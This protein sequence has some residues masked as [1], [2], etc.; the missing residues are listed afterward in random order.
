MLDTG[1]RVTAVDGAGVAVVDI[2]RNVGD[3]PGLGVAA[4]SRARIVVV[5]VDRRVLHTAHGVAAVHGTRVVVVDLRRSARL[6]IAAPVAGLGAIADGVV[7][8]RRARG[9][10]GLAAFPGGADLVR[11]RIA[12]GTIGVPGALR[13]SAAAAANGKSAAAPRLIAAKSAR[14]VPSAIPSAPRR[15]TSAPKISVGT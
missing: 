9:H 13:R 8:A 11:A 10:E 6:A 1:D 2:D 12:I 7:P 5:D 14:G 3:D 4:V 15:T